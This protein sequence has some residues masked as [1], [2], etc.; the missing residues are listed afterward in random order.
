MQPVNQLLF[1]IAISGMGLNNWSEGMD[2]ERRMLGRLAPRLGIKPV[3]FDVGANHGQFATLARNA[4][5]DARILSFEPNPA[6]FKLL[7][8]A[9]DRLNIEI[10]NVGCGSEPGQMILFDSSATDAS[11]LATFVPGVFE[12][13]GI[14]PVGIPAEVVTLDQFC[15]DHGIEHINLLKI[16]VEGFERSVL[17]GAQRMLTAGRIDAVQLEFNEMNLDS[18]TTVEEVQAL[19]PGL[20][21]H[22]VLFDGNLLSLDNAPPVRRNLFVYQNLVALRP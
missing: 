15:A 6:S 7:G 9:A 18:H 3:I 8:A 21:L 11:G 17:E 19:L 5:P 13:Q 16:D 14:E 4:L 2:D 1:R 20:V 10:F 22:R 12:R